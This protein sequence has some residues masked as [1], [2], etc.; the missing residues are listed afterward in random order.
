[1]ET[2]SVKRPNTGNKGQAHRQEIKW[3]GGVS[4]FCIIPSH[5]DLTTKVVQQS[6]I[7][8]AAM[9]AG[10]PAAHFDPVQI[11]K[12]LFL[13]DDRVPGAGGPHFAFRAYNYGPFDAAVYEV[14]ADLV[15]A[16]D[17]EIDRSGPYRTFTLSKAGR[18][19]GQ[20]VLR[21]LKRRTARS[22]RRISRWV[23]SLSFWELVEAIYRQYPEMAVNTRIPQAA[24]RAERRSLNSRQAF[25]SG[26]TRPFDIWPPEDDVRPELSPDERDAMAMATDWWTVG[27]DLRSAIKGISRSNER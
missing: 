16:D 25:L 4:P 6:D 3:C 14:L 12:L 19:R 22:I 26:M 18:T 11:Q 17:A 9:A 15:K 21:R 7:V 13:I 23:L 8:L 20:A 1:M 27:N 2:K 10:G 5:M 24:L